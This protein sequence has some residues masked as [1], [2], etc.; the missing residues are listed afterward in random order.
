MLLSPQISCHFFSFFQMSV[1]P[2]EKRQKRAGEFDG[3]YAYTADAGSDDD[4]A[5]RVFGDEDP[6]R[7]FEQPEPDD[8]SSTSFHSIPRSVTG[9]NSLADLSAVGGVLSSVHLSVFS[10]HAYDP[11]PETMIPCP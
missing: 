1:P 4:S 2:R 6:S 7:D 3:N 10:G 9:I 11:L 5:A 8:R